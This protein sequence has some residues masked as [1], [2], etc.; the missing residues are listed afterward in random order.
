[1][2]ALTKTIVAA[3]IG[4]QQLDVDTGIEYRRLDPDVFRVKQEC[5][6]FAVRGSG[7][8]KATELRLFLAG[9]L[10]KPAIAPIGATTRCKVAGKPVSAIGPHNHIATVAIHSRACLKI[11]RAAGDDIPCIRHAIVLARPSATNAH[12]ASARVAVR[13][14]VRSSKR[15]FSPGNRYGPTDPNASTCIN[16]GR[17]KKI[18]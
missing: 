3:R 18:S 16:G 7:V 4:I 17:C 2:Q 13:D 1:M 6:V 10:D 9:Y 5:A 8:C 15:E 11:G 12:C 14:Q